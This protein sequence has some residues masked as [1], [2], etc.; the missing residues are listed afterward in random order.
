MLARVN[1]EL[2]RRTIESRFAT[3]LYGVLCDG[4]LT[5]SSA[6]HNPALIVGPGE[7]RRLERGGLILGAFPGASFE[8]ETV[9]LDPGDVVVV[10]SDGITE[11]VRPDG[12]EFGEER[13][14]AAIRGGRELPPTRLLHEVLDSVREF[15][16]D[17]KQSDDLTAL[18]LRYTGS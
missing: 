9:S 3:L 14:L 1:D 11:A 5:Y 13:L 15:I 12:S 8:E 4:R 16:G 7:V 6:G 17:A 10:F 2:V 18:V